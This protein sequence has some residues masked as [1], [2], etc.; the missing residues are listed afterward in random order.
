MQKVLGGRTLRRWH[1]WELVWHLRK[2]R[3]GEGET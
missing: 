1:H 2:G 3:L